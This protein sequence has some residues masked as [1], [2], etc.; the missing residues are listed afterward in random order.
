[1]KFCAAAEELFISSCHSIL[2]KLGGT[3]N[4][5]SG[6]FKESVHVPASS[7]TF[8]KSTHAFSGRLDHPDANSNANGSDEWDV[9]L[10]LTSSGK[11]SPNVL[12]GFGPRQRTMTPANAGNGGTTQNH[13]NDQQPPTEGES[14]QMFERRI[15]STPLIWEEPGFVCMECTSS[16]VGVRLWSDTLGW[17]GISSSKLLLQEPTTVDRHASDEKIDSSIPPP[18]SCFQYSSERDLWEADVRLTWKPHYPVEKLPR[19][20]SFEF[21]VGAASNS[22]KSD[23]ARE[24]ISVARGEYQPLPADE[25][26]GI[27]PYVTLLNHVPSEARVL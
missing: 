8:L 26:T 27:A 25:F 4:N 11:E 19:P 17:F 24:W 20:G 2:S 9:A 1:M 13:N 7:P 14:Q 6:D 22:P 12:V 21:F 18:L 23:G 15:L 10:R 16:D 3:S 5:D